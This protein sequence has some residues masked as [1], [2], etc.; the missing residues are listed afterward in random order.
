M[1]ERFG[2]QNTEM[3]QR[4]WE[5]DHGARDPTIRS[6]P[7]EGADPPTSPMRRSLVHWTI[8]GCKFLTIYLRSYWNL[9]PGRGGE[10]APYRV[11]R[12]R[13]FLFWNERLSRPYSAALTP[14]K[15]VQSFRSVH[16]YLFPLG[17]YCSTDINK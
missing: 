8:Y 17:G 1:P 13:A 5:F 12:W 6:P 4:S 16:N 10:R 2:A 9:P 15:T 3:R 11:A 7:A 14:P